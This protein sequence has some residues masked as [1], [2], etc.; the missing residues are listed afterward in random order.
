MTRWLALL[1]AVVLPG[2]L[3]IAAVVWL[4][5]RWLANR[6]ADLLITPLG[7]QHYRF[8]GHDEALRLRTEARRKAAAGIRTRANLVESGAPVSD[9]LRRVK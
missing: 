7:P 1:A 4:R 5:R 8:T 6:A 2:G 3:V 9:V